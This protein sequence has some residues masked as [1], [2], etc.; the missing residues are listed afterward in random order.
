MTP[1]LDER[2]R[3]D[4]DTP[5]PIRVHG[6]QVSVE[7]WCLLGTAP[8]PPPVRLVTGDTILHQT[9]RQPRPD[10][11]QQN[12]AAP[13]AAQCG[14]SIVG[15]LPAGV[16]L[17]RLEAE[18]PDGRWQ[19]F[20]TLCLVVETPS[21]V[22]GL[23]SPSA[24]RPVTA[25]VH[26]EGWVL[27]PLQPV[28]SLSLRYGHQEIPCQIGLRRTD[29]P[30][31]YP[32]SPHASRSGFKSS[33]ILSAGRGPLRLKARLADGSA[34]LVRT[35]L[36]VDIPTDENIAPELN[37]GAGRIML[38]GAAAV[39]SPPA[40]RTAHPLNLLFVLHGSF[41]ANSALHV[42]A[43][44]NELAGMGHV[45]TVA[46][47]HDLATLA[48]HR[49][50]RFRGILHKDAADGV[51]YPDGCGPALIHAWTTRENVRQLTQ[52]LR[53]LHPAAKVV[54]HLEDNEL[55]LLAVQLGRD[56][57][58]LL[59]L[60]T[61]ELDALVPPELSHPHHSQKFLTGADGVTVITEKLQALAPVGR[62]CH[63]LWPAAD[64]RY[65]Y[66]RPLP[67][68]F[69]Q[70]LARD[71]GETMLF[72][73]GNAHAAN[74]LEMRELYAAILQL[75][76]AAPP[77]TLIR[78]GLDTVDFLGDLAPQVAPHVLCL[79]QILHHHHL[80]GLMALADIFVQPG[81]PDAFNDYRFPSKLPEFFAI[82]RPVILP[83]TNL[84]TLVRHGEDAYVL[85][86]ANAAGIAR[87]VT[88][89]RA[90]P[91]L[92]GRLAKGA[93]AFAE[94]HFSWR[95]SAVELAKFYA[96]LTA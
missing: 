11:A 93:V 26:I 29:V 45:C 53:D 56:A 52:R 30:A 42:T 90:D 88:E 12:P 65:F 92:A 3:G 46:V 18:L 94:K 86:Q 8:T 38:T 25:R 64:A 59:P 6:G 33:L 95:R 85:D 81:A 21:L 9:S 76:R 40:E 22:G 69:R 35:A 31:L 37:L 72:Y 47:T 5:R 58:E 70:L 7:G 61:A 63:L 43:L 62:P 66:P 57:A 15:V 77:V 34:A 51:T 23:D 68:Q 96:T 39:G 41:A 89:L 87:A 49:A 48:R 19:S 28:H 82:G 60:P 14:F 27:H 71:P 50:S 36:V 32:D 4:V 83:R 17:S 13:A 91:A 84:G 24:T 80:P 2:L 1:Q 73:H 54:V 78:I 74:A 67:G 79:G 55:Q 10:I 16:H 44:A 75:N 20:K